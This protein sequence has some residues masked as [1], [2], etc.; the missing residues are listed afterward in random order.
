ME[1][2][3]LRRFVIG[4]CVL[5][6]VA[7]VIYLIIEAVNMKKDSQNSGKV[8]YTGYEKRYPLEEVSVM[9]P[10]DFEV[11]YPE[12]IDEIAQDESMLVPYDEYYTWEGSTYTGMVCITK[13]RNGME[14]R[15]YM[16]VSAIPTYEEYYSS[17]GF[18]VV[19]REAGTVAG[20]PAAA[21][22]FDYTMTYQTG[23]TVTFRVY[24]VFMS[25]E[26][27]MYTVFFNCESWDFENYKPTFDKIAESVEIG[28]AA[29]IESEPVS[30]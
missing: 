19:S 4:F 22:T 26:G 21:L 29:P 23:E 5:L 16:D 20:Y 2:S 15:A 1:N 3:F 30:E 9:I 10:D 12:D 14:P 7:G 8:D 13:E 27:Y 24:N 28:V 17:L 25:K 18:N 11:I 6:S